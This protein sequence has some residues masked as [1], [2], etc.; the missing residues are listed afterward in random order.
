MNKIK[1]FFNELFFGLSKSTRITLISCGSFIMLTFVILLFFVLF[2]ITPSEGLI[3]LRSRIVVSS[4]D[5]E[6]AVTTVQSETDEEIT[7]AP[8]TVTTVAETLN[9]ILPTF[10]S[11]NLPVD[12]NYTY[13]G[14]GIRT[15]LPGETYPTTTAS[16]SGTGTGQSATATGTTLHGTGTTPVVTTT[17]SP[18]D[19]SSGN[20]SS[21]PDNTVPVPTVPD[22]SVPDSSVPDDDPPEL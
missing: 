10:T 12:P 17:I 15:G 19:D 9:E 11:G 6:A 2:P 4:S 20:D 21:I 13:T 18:P 16:V 3:D 7:E 14:N 1:D 5:S 8:I 22:S